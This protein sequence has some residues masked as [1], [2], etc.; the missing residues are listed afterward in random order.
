MKHSLRAAPKPSATVLSYQQAEYLF[1]NDPV[2]QGQ[3]R[4]DH[5]Q[6]R[7]RC[8]IFPQDGSDHHGVGLTE[9]EALLN[10][11]MAYHRY[12]QKHYHSTSHDPANP[13]AELP[14]PAMTFQP[15]RPELFTAL[16]PT[17]ST[18]SS[19]DAYHTGRTA[20]FERGL[21]GEFYEAGG[22][23]VPAKFAN[24][25]SGW[26]AYCNQCER[27]NRVWKKGWADGQMAARWQKFPHQKPTA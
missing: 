3:F 18:P 7:W 17:W 8:D 9:A 19:E 2:A 23:W 24:K 22:P 15:H 20:G 10:A 16:N 12:L 1:P 14:F 21:K 5:P 27:V 4:T 26:D 6:E 11:S 13:N 25:D